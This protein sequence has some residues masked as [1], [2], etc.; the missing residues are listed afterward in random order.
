MFSGLA[1][2][3]L[4]CSCAVCFCCVRPWFSFFSTTPRVCMAK[5]VSEMIDLCR[6]EVYNLNQ[7][8]KGKKVCMQ[9]YVRFSKVLAN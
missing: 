9:F 4:F 1:Y 8:V 2:S 3:R 5:K 7:S 6:W